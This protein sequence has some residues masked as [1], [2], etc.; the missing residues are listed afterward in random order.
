MGLRELL[1]MTCR[2]MVTAG[3]SCAMTSL[4]RRATTWVG[5]TRTNRARGDRP[6][7]NEFNNKA[8]SYPAF[9][10]LRAMLESGGLD[11]SHINSSLSTP[12][13]ATSSG[14]RN[15]A[16]A[17]PCRSARPQMSLHAIT[18]IGLGRDSS[19]LA[20]TSCSLSQ[21]EIQPCQC[22]QFALFMR[23]LK[24]SNPLF[25]RKSLNL[26]S[27]SID[28]PQSVNPQK[29]KRRNPRS[30]RCVAPSRAIASESV[31]IS[32]KLSPVLG[33]RNPVS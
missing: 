4:E 24:Q 8:A 16:L 20:I 22:I 9:S 3:S 5:S 28:H 18:P 1:R 10:R 6:H 23:Y 13:T 12:T 2:A 27:R 19:H 11:N 29:A 17:H 15:P 31:R 30:S 26:L 33:V 7:I 14:T 32:P 25:L 21:T